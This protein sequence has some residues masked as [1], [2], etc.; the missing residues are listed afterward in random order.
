LKDIEDRFFSTPFAF[1][2]AIENHSVIG[3]L[4]LFKRKIDYKGERIILGGIGNLC[5]KKEKRR[6]G[7]ATALLKKAMEELNTQ[8]CDVAYL[9]TDIHNP[10]MVK[11]YARVGFGPLNKP[12]TYLGRSGKRYTETDGIIAPLQSNEKFGLI[13]NGKDI[14]DLDT[15]NW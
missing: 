9:C 13:M 12:Y 14:L 1:L 6:M 8:K 2:L 10:S 15:G 5:T 7:V 4:L 11:L 3:T